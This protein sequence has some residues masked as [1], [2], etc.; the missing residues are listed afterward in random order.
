MTDN[1]PL[2]A[3]LGVTTHEVA[4]MTRYEQITDI[5][6]ACTHKHF[7][8]YE[9]CQRLAF[10]LAAGYADF[11]EYPRDQ[12]VFVAL[13]NNLK[14]GEKT[15]PIGIDP[16]MVFGDDGFW[17]FCFRIKYE[18]KGDP[19]YMYEF[20]KLGL[21]LNGH[22]ATVRAEGDCEI[23]TTVAGSSSDLF[24]HSS[25]I[26]WSALHHHCFVHPSA[27]ASLGKAVTP[28]LTVNRTARKLRLR[29]PSAL[30]APAAGYLAR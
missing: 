8:Y 13:D 2:I 20:I 5:A 3:L 29:V 28:T 24:N 15:E 6:V 21:K 27:S 17:Y 1:F 25:T 10:S 7:Q 16:S 30:R 12:V 23:D 11:L 19:G 14:R 4:E 22:I 9:S 18:N 26:P